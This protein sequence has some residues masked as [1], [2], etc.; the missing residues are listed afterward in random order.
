MKFEH[1]SVLLNECIEGLDIKPD[2]TY[3]DGTLGGAGHAG[4]VCSHLSEGG[5]FIGIDQDN[6]ALTVSKE[7]LS[8][9]K[10]KVTL[11]KSNFVDVKNVLES[12]QVDKV[13]GMLIDLG[14]S[15]HQLD[16]PSR[17]FSYMHDAPLDMR[18]NQDAAYNAYEV[19]NTM[20]EDDLYHIIKEYGEERWAKRIASFIVT[21]RQAKPIETTYELVEVIKKAIPQGARKDGPHPAKRT[22]Q[23]IRIAVNR[24]LEIIEPTI[25][26][27]VGKLNKG[28]RLCIITFHS[29]EDRIV[30][31]AFKELEDP[32]TCSKHLPMCVCGKKPE[33]KVITR[34]PILPS[35]EEIEINPRSRSAKLRIIEKI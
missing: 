27:I 12:L 19:V 25:K 21:E 11:V 22:F 5:H 7:R 16:E 24:E 35:D 8:G 26:D 29:L 23:A 28:G 13:D 32:C 1:V 33:V 30:K 20:S 18:M 3:V 14:V 9:V 10:P 2:G 34:K 6:N 17:G 31:H 4:V 15:S